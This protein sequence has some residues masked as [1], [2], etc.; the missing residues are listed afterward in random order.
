MD[1]ASNLIFFL[2]S[3]L[4]LAIF[5]IFKLAN[6]SYQAAPLGIDPASLL[7]FWQTILYGVVVISALII[8]V[9]CY[10][11]MVENE[12]F[13]VFDVFLAASFLFIYAF[14]DLMMM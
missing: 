10:E 13:A 3:I 1:D 4:F 6:D 5:F 14:A 12:S 7:I 11:W 2:C 8:V 9:W